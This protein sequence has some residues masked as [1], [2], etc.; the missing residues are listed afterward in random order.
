MSLVADLGIFFFGG[1]GGVDE[2]KESKSIYS[3]KSSDS[4]GCHFPIFK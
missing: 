4:L 2:L 1:E 3:D